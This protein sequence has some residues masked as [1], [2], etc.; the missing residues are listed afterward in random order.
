MHVRYAT[1]KVVIKENKVN[2]SEI[3]ETTHHTGTDQI[4]TLKYDKYETMDS[5]RNC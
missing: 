4:N 5:G 1:I 3:K 2:S